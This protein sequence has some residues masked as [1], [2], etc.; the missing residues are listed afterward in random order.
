MF[1]KYNAVLRGLRSGVPVLR[2]T[3][4]S[5]CCSKEVVA[6]FKADEI[7]FE[8]AVNSVNRYPNTLHAIN[9]AVVKASKLST[10]RKVYRGIKGMALPKEFWEPNEYGDEHLVPNSYRDPP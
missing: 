4:V 2:N 9:S 1:V 10:A 5:L 6:K 3:M 7:S 8:E